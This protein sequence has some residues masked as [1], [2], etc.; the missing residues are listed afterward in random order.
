MSGVRP[1]H[2]VWSEAHG[3]RNALD[4]TG[5]PDGLQPFQ[6]PGIPNELK[7]AFIIAEKEIMQ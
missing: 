7:I 1:V 3:V 5:R 2:L 4:R 6:F